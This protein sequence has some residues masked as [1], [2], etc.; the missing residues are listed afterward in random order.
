MIGFHFPNPGSVLLVYKGKSLNRKLDYSS[1]E[2]IKH[3]YVA[4]MVCAEEGEWMMKMERRERGR[5]T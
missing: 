1:V 4:Q 5:R 2:V 3:Q